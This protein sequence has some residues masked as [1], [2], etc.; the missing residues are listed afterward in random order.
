MVV[1]GDK[2][3]FAQVIMNVLANSRDAIAEKLDSGKVARGDINI[4][5]GDDDDK[6]RVDITDNGGGIPVDILERIFEPY[7]TTKEDQKGTGVGL[8]MSKVVIEDHM[9][10]RISIGNAGDGT[11]LSIVLEKA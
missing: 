11:I 4:K 5:I 3:V 10:G 6:L 9:K 2:G 7:F 8:Y 1:K